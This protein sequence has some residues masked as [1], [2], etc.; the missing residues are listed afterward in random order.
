MPKLQRTGPSATL[1]HLPGA[2][3]VRPV[4]AG[5]MPK[6]QRIGPSVTL[7]HL[8]GAGVVRPVVAAKM[9]K[10]QRTGPSVT[11]LHLPGPAG[12]AGWWRGRCRSS[13]APA[14]A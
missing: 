7:R 10:L 4:V 6:L 2:G 14:R 8:P 5:K 3:V 12:G 9:P 11:L 1:R 13:S